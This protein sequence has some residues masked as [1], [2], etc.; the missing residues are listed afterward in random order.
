MPTVCAFEKMKMLRK[1][2]TELKASLSF[3]DR[4]IYFGSKRIFIE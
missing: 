1:A 4:G 2:I 3:I